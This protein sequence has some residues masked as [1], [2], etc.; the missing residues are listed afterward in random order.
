MIQL[1]QRTWNEINMDLAA[2]MKHLRRRRKISQ[3]ELSVRSGVSF[4]SVR[5]FEQT[6]E[7]SL[8]SLTKLALAL[9]IE[10]ELDKLFSNVPF[11]S[12]EEVIHAQ[13]HETERILP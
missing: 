8:Q 10:S 6:G 13:T 11:Q 2:R 1:Y 9:G 7:I 12:I 3:K 5:R 4:G